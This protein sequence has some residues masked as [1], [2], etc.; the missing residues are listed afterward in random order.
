[1]D[2]RTGAVMVCCPFLGL[3]ATVFMEKDQ[4]VLAQLLKAIEVMLESG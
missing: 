3:L 1:M 4:E 2:W